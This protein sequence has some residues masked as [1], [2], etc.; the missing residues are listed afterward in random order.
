MFPTFSLH[1]VI[2]LIDAITRVLGSSL[3]DGL[4][5]A[6]APH[7]SALREGTGD[8]LGCLKLLFIKEK[9]FLASEAG[10]SNNDKRNITAKAI[11]H[12][13]ATVYLK[14]KT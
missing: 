13:L 6:L 5:A 9:T 8:M 7:M 11:R 12:S 4:L 2:Q 3:Y 1:E 14:C 10:V